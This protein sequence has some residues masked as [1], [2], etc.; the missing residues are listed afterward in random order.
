MTSRHLG[1]MLGAAAAPL[2]LAAPL[3]T[4]PNYTNAQPTSFSFTTHDTQGRDVLVNIDAENA[5]W[6]SLGA[7]SSNVRRWHTGNVTATA[8]RRVGNEWVTVGAL[9]RG[10]LFLT[11]GDNVQLVTQPEG[12]KA[13][14]FG[15]SATWDVTTADA[16]LPTAFSASY[17]LWTNNTQAISGLGLSQISRI[18]TNASGFHTSGSYL[19]FDENQA[20][21]RT[22]IPAPATLG[23]LGAAALLGRRRRLLKVQMPASSSMDLAQA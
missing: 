11:L 14:Y 23:V 10:S 1:L 12:Q 22:P 5:L 7:D 6:E 21:N 3:G 4:A 19:T 20:L 2:T 9:H 8:A 17:D 18:N 15:I 13:D 16:D